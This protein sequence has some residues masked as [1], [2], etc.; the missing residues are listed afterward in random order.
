V[1][2]LVGGGLQLLADN[3]TAYPPQSIDPGTL[4]ELDVVG[5]VRSAAVAC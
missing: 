2:R 1:Q 4:S 5:R 3:G